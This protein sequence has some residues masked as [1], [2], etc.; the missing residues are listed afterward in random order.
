MK[1]YQ[2]HFYGQ[3]RIDGHTKKETPSIMELS[4]SKLFSVKKRLI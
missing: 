3:F 1:Q 2:S 4:V